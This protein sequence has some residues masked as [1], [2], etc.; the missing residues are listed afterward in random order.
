M[1]TT[2]KVRPEPASCTHTPWISGTA[3]FSRLSQRAADRINARSLKVRVRRFVGSGTSQNRIIAIH[4]PL[5]SEHGLFNFSAGI[6]SRPFSKRSFEAFFVVTKFAFK[7]NFRIRGNGQPVY[8][9]FKTS[10]GCSR[11][12]P[13]QS[14]S[15]S[16]GGT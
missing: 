9:P 11:K 4:H 15:E 1:L 6:I 5:D 14:S 8:L 10:I 7:N 3:A 16:P 13:T 2:L 12:P